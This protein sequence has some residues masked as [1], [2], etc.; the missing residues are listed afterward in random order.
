MLA[1]LVHGNERGNL[2]T[3]LNTTIQAISALQL[4]LASLSASV[5]SQKGAVVALTKRR[6]KESVRIIQII[7]SSWRKTKVKM[8]PKGK[9]VAISL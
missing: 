1:R 2:K 7:V 6:M 3:R 8:R 9:K 5:A 4:K